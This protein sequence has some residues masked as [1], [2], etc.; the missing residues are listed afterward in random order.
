MS[1]L[2]V[3]RLT[4][5]LKRAFVLGRGQGPVAPEISDELRASVCLENDRMEYRWLGGTYSWSSFTAV[6]AG[7]AGFASIVALLNP[8]RSGQLVTV[9][10]IRASGQSDVTLT[11]EATILATFAQVA[12]IIQRDL[13]QFGQVSSAQIWSRNGVAGFGGLG[14][15]F[16]ATDGEL[17]PEYV[18]PPGFAL[19]IQATTSNTA[20]EVS[21][22][23][24]ERLAESSE[25]PT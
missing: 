8:T 1:D 21:L 24:R 11:T 17:P 22:A 15:R 10:R 13:R 12:Q 16:M 6:A 9:E 18:I 7:G 14:Y 25:L 4:T 23:W 20:N 2:Q 5:I 3:T 19:V